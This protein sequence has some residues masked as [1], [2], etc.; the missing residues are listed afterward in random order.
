MSQ[1]WLFHSGGKQLLTY[2]NVISITSISITIL[3]HTGNNGILQNKNDMKK[4]TS[5]RANALLVSD[6]ATFVTMVTRVSTA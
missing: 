4:M 1:R 5:I 6:E 2:L 3:A